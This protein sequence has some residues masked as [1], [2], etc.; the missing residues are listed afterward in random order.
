ME[1]V[2]IIQLP[3]QSY[4][5]R[6]FIKRVIAAGSAVSASGYLFHGPGALAQDS[7]GIRSFNHVA[8]PM[9][10]TEAMVASQAALLRGLIQVRY[11]HHNRPAG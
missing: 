10:N 2:E 6:R 9:Q 4:P 3:E 11:H 5:R 7:V 8:A 1:E